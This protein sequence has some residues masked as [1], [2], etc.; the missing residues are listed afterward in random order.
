MTLIT[1]EPVSGISSIPVRM[2][3]AWS[4]RTW[5]GEIRAEEEIVGVVFSASARILTWTRSRRSTPTG[6]PF[7]I[8]LGPEDLQWSDTWIRIDLGGA[9]L[10]GRVS[11]ES[12]G[13][14]DE[15]DLTGSHVTGEPSW[16]FGGSPVQ[17]NSGFGL[18][19][20]PRSHVRFGRKRIWR[21]RLLLRDELSSPQRAMLVEQRYGHM[22]IT[23][24][25]T[26]S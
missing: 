26:E 7:A 2:D 15:I 25:V 24:D 6:L 17:S 8:H 16:I 5:Y 22:S 12:C 11:L 20:I 10:D 9:W 18:L 3:G 1:F 4:D 23:D 14:I 13:L 21:L 19:L